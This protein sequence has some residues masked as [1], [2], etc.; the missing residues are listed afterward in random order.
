M[1]NNDCQHEIWFAGVLDNFTENSK[2]KCLDCG[3]EKV[4]SITGVGRANVVTVNKHLDDFKPVTFERVQKTYN[5]LK[6]ANANT[7]KSRIRKKYDI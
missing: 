6:K 7:A 3:Y 5:E 1:Q 4:I 2:C